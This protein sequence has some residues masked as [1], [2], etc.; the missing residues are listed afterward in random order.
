MSYRNVFSCAPFCVMAGFG[1]EKA[2]NN[3]D[4]KRHMAYEALVILGLLALLNFICRLWPILLLIILG[5]FVAALRLLFLSSRNVEVIEPLPLLPEPVRE[6]TEQDVQALAYAV[7]LRRIT[8][9]V[10]SEY[11]DARWVWEMPDAQKRLQDGLEVFI[12]L[13]RAGGYRRARVLVS[14][15]QVTGLEYLSMPQQPGFSQPEGEDGSGQNQDEPE[16]QNYE[17]LAFEW[18]EAHI[19]E[20][21]SRCNEAI[22]EHLSELILLA[23][24]LPVRES[25]PDICRELMRSG[26]EEAKC[27]PEGIKIN[28][29]Q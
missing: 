2:M 16:T 29:T 14:N 12:L 5:I 4:R 13:N 18:V 9:L 11:P 17:L 25:W 19:L 1:K 21:N 7:I 28:L 23:E 22:G 10:L 20:L 6:P 26:L 27:V 3:K 24:E 15:L 8:E